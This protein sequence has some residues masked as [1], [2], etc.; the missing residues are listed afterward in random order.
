MT[1]GGALGA[2]P[3]APGTNSAGT[4]LPSGRHAAKASTVIGAKDPAVD[5]ENR[6]IDQTI[7]SICKGC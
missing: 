3:A 1:T 2:S 7:K 6:K 4:A 5:K